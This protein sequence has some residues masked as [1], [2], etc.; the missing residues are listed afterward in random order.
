MPKET[1]QPQHSMGE[2]E[3]EPCSPEVR[4][5]TLSEPVPYFQSFLAVL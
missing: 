4:Q 3:V 1:G 5:G 2:E